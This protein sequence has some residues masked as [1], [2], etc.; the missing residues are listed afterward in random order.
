M[1]WSLKWRLPVEGGISIVLGLALF[2]IRGAEVLLMLPVVGIVLIIAGVL[3]K[4]HKKT[5]TPK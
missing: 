5:E 1:D 3:Y 4:P 2:I